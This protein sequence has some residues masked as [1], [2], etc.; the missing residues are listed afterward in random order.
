MHKRGI[1]LRKRQRLL[2]RQII[3][4]LYRKYYSIPNTTYLTKKNHTF[5]K[6]SSYKIP[7]KLLVLNMFEKRLDVSLC[8]M[9]LAPSLK[10]AQVL[11]HSGFVYV[12]NKQITNTRYSVDTWDLV[13]IASDSYI[14]YMRYWYIRNKYKRY[15]FKNKGLR[16][17][18]ISQEKLTNAFGFK[19]RLLSEYDLS[20]NDRIKSKEVERLF[21]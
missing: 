7:Q 17:A 19:T 5:R 13:S 9:N 6:V 1:S 18:S 15:L 21:L 20:R 3:Y 4:K 10:I 14:H 11:I 12:N 16:T 2:K 8:R